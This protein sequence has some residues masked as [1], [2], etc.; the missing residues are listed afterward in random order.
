VADETFAH[1]AKI[2]RLLHDAHRAMPGPEE[3]A[4]GPT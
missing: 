1:A 4:D 3:D 2:D